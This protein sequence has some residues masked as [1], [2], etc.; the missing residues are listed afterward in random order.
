MDAERLIDH[1]AE[2]ADRLGD[3]AGRAGWDAPVPACDWT[4]RE[5]VVHVG[6]VHRWAADIVATSSPTSETSA[7]DAVGTGPADEELLTWYGAGHRTLV[8]TLRAAPADLDCA[9]FLPAD[10]PRHFWARRQAHETTIHRVDAEGAAGKVTTI[11]PELAQ[12]GI[13]EIL[14]GFARRKRNAP[15]AAGTIGLDAVDGPGRV[16]RLGGERIESE[17]GA[18]PGSAD[19]VVRGASA[20]LYRWLWNRPS[21]AVVEGRED[22]AAVWAQSVR[23]R[24]S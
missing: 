8:D 13:A 1:L 9:T 2:N 23:V 11:D 21:D 7:G 3:A 19:T 5:L 22:L 16:I 18:D 4:V 17:A 10:S 6:G 20:D 24:W 12:D 14:D 15:R